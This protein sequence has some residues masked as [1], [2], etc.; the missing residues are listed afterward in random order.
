M[1]FKI[2]ILNNNNNKFIETIVLHEIKITLNLRLRLRRL[3]PTI[4]TDLFEL[5]II[6]LVLVF[7]KRKKLK[8]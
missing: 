3:L 6:F 4:S 8:K 2:I 7:N 5:A 1:G